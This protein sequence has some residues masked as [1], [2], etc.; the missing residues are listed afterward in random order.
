MGVACDDKPALKRFFKK[1]PL[2][3]E[4]IVDDKQR[5]GI[6]ETLGVMAFPTTVLLGKDGKVIGTNLHGGRLARALTKHLEL[7]DETT[8]KLNGA[9]KAGHGASRDHDTDDKAG[10]VARQSWSAVG[11]WVRRRRRGQ[12]WQRSLPRNEAVPGRSLVGSGSA[13]RKGLQGSRQRQECVLSKAEFAKRHPVIESYVG[14]PVGPGPMPEDPGKNYALFTGS[15]QPIDDR[16]IMGAMFHRSEDSGTV[17]KVKLE[18]IPQSVSDSKPNAAPGERTVEDLVKATVVLAGDDGR[19]FFT[20]GAVLV[21]SDGLALT[22]YHVAQ[23]LERGKVTGLTSDGKPHA[24]LEF[25]AGNKKRDV[26][27]IRLEGTD[28][29]HVAIAGSTPKMGDD[30]VM[31]H[32]SENRFFT[33]DRGYVVRHPLVGE[34]PWMEISADYAP[35]GSGCGIFNKQHELIGLVSMI[36]F[37]TGPELAEPFEGDEGFGPGGPE[38]S[39]QEGSDG[40]MGPSERGLLM[41]K[42]AVPVSAIHGLW[43]EKK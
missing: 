32:H 37:G 6:A 22:N 39:D 18:D 8:A 27:L 24:V 7:D 41:V 5:G 12:R 36:Q 11:D 38:G 25:I 4:N 3:W 13:V 14:V 26:A 19:G 21:S 31:I 33:Y 9:L 17:L 42:H 2:P 29:P 20:G 28:F 10:M 23:S 34:N 35:G 40:S 1:K 15:D 16:S 43:S 30:L